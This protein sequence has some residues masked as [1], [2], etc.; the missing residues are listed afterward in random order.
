VTENYF[1]YFTEI[2]EH[3][4]R[5][6]GTGL[7]L[8]SPVDWALIEAW[9]NGGIPLEA[10]LRGIDVAFEKWRAR[11]ANARR[12]QINSLAYCTQAVTAE[13]QAM[14]NGKPVRKHAEPEA[15]M[16]QADVSSYL[17]RNADALQAAGLTDLAAAVR[18]LDNPESLAD[19]ETLEQWLTTLEEKMIARIRASASDEQMLEARQVLDRQLKPYRGKMSTEQLSMLERQFLDR[20]LLETA[21]LPRLSLF[22]LTM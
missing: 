11:P 20:R 7:F 16:P 21:R 6:R 4:Q 13:A 3:F 17:K 12:H 10:V 14:A 22:Y 18:D 19:M 15:S 2:E 5:A 9:K 1:N 8:L